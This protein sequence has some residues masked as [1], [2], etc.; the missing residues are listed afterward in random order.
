LGKKEVGILAIPTCG[1]N[2]TKT[3]IF[4]GK[5]AADPDEHELFTKAFAATGAGPSFL[6]V[7]PH[8]FRDEPS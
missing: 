5:T 7:P 6:A 4:R 2:D 8:R 1:V 3:Q